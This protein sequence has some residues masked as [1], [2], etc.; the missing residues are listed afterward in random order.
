M[1]ANKHFAAVDLG[2]NSFHLII[3]K[4][5][6]N[7]FQIVCKER[8]PIRLAAYLDEHGILSPEG[9]QRALACLAHFR[10]V[11]QHYTC[12]GAQAVGTASFRRLKEPKSFCEQA[13]ATLGLPI[14]V[15]TGEE[16]AKFIYDGVRYA[17]GKP[18]NVSRLV[19]DIGGGS[20]EVIL[21]A[22]SQH[23]YV[24]SFPIGCVVLQQAHYPAG[25]LS[26]DTIKNMHAQ[27]EAMFE[28]AKADFKQ[29]RWRACFAS[30]GTAQTLQLLQKE[31]EHAA[32]QRDFA[33]QVL[34]NLKQRPPTQLLD[35]SVIKSDRQLIFPAGLVILTTLLKLLDVPSFYVSSAALRE[36]IL[37]RLLGQ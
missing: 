36:G 20:T 3:V 23:Q 25:I 29:L 13:S 19:I 32:I 5:R 27:T 31:G 26:P 9:Q 34:S 28:S 17:L 6:K 24:Q 21:G 37:A 30:S 15:L 1:P 16:E 22:G 33:E 14:T 2:S 35:F 18:D 4:Q 11:L 7:D 12:A 8:Q 10:Q